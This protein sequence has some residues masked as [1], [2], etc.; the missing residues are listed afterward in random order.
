MKRHFELQLD[1]TSAKNHV[2][3]TSEQSERVTKAS[4]F[5][6]RVNLVLPLLGCLVKFQNRLFAHFHN[7]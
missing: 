7:R 4:A 6:A 2:R 5:I 3:K 1:Q